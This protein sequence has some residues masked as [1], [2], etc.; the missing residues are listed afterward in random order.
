MD[1]KQFRKEYS[2]RRNA[3]TSYEIE[4][5]SALIAKSLFTTPEYLSSE[6]IFVYMSFGSE[7]HTAPIISDAFARS[8]RVMLPVISGQSMDFYEIFSFEHLTKNSFGIYEPKPDDLR[9]CESDEK[10]LVIVPGLIFSHERHRI[11]YGRGYYDRYLCARKSLC[12]AGLSFGV[13]IADF[14]AEIHD[15]ALDIVIVEN[16]IIR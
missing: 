15:I 5:K 12:N 14:P 11:G 3:L 16:E 7:V 1:K 10:T 6:K 13:Q 4:Y 2:V 8:K 9:H